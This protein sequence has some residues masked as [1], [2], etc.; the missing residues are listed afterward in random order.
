MEQKLDNHCYKL[1]VVFY[2]RYYCYTSDVNID[3]V[4]TLDKEILKLFEEMFIEFGIKEDS[5]EIF[6]HFFWSRMNVCS[7]WQ[8]AVSDFGKDFSH[9]KDYINT[10]FDDFRNFKNENHQN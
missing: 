9:T 8:K 5:I 1:A 2:S 10:I 4:E 7:E 3:V 6:R